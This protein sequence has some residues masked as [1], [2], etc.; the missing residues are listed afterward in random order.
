MEEKLWDINKDTGMEN[1]TGMSVRDLMNEFDLPVMDSLGLLPPGILA[2]VE[3]GGD[4]SGATG[5]GEPTQP[6]SKKTASSVTT[7]G[8]DEEDDVPRSG[9][10]LREDTSTDIPVHARQGKKGR[11]T[12]KSSLGSLLTPRPKANAE[13]PRNPIGGGGGGGGGRKTGGG[14]RARTFDEV[15]D[16]Y[17][18]VVSDFL[19]T[20]E[21]SAVFTDPQNP[22]PGT[23]KRFA[24]ECNGRIEKLAREDDM[25]QTQKK[26]LEVMRKM[27]WI[28]EALLKQYRKYKVDGPSV[29]S[30]ATLKEQMQFAEVEPAVTQL[31]ECNLPICVRRTALELRVAQ[32]FYDKAV[33]ELLVLQK[34]LELY[35]VS[36]AAVPFGEDFEYI[37]DFS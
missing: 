20:E 13:G 3:S 9:F 15:C 17:R 30:L 6:R 14:R 18:R 19:E 8:A 21:E 28:S 25:S 37:E 29:N 2:L 5:T 35:S 7:G 27:L 4:G 16:V 1:S 34:L 12:K 26:E 24:N 32:E 33:L 23:L 31:A 10:M 36:N 22:L 11:S